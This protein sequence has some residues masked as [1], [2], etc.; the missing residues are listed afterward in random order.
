ML[1]HS[2]DTKEPETALVP[3]RTVKE[4][5]NEEGAILL[6]VHHGR[7]FGLD[8]VGLKTWEMLKQGIPTAQIIKTLAAQCSMPEAQVHDDVNEFICELQKCNLLIPESTANGYS[9]GVLKSLWR[10]L[11]SVRIGV[12]R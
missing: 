10:R 8:P 4:V 1:L 7:T 3:S 9:V 12:V 6:D 11:T 5:T 2:S